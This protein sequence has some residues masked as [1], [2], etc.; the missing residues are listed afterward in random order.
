MRVRSMSVCGDASNVSVS[1]SVNVI[2]CD[3]VG[4]NVNIL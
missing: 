4:E 1:L 2:K 3:G